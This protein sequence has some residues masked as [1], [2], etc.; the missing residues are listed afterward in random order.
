MLSLDPDVAE[1]WGPMP[2]R[3]WRALGSW[4]LVEESAAEAVRTRTRGLDMNRIALWSGDPLPG[5]PDAAHADTEILERACERALAGLRGRGPGGAVFVDRDGTLIA[6]RGYLSDPAG[7]ELLPGTTRALRRLRAAG[8]PVIVVSNQSGV[9]R[10]LYSLS[11][12]HDTMARLRVELRRSGVELDGVY[13]CPHRPEEGCPCRKPGTWLLE[14]AAEDQHLSLR[15]SYLVGDKLLDVEAAHRAGARGILVRSGYGRGEEE[16]LGGQEPTAGPD[17]V[18]EDLE[19]A[20][21]WILAREEGE[22]E[23]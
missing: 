13:F 18:C 3:A 12:A 9:G 21:A 2:R 16:S 22:E 15:E 14:R 20:A 10:G 7:V 23:A 17:V 4:G 8:L 1:R 19:G 11:Q 6:E 5:A